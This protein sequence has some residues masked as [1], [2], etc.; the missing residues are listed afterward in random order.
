MAGAILE[1]AVIGEL[2]KAALHRGE[3]ARLHFSR[4]A[5]GVEVDVV[6]QQW[7]SGA[8]RL[9]PLEVRT[10]ATT[11]ARMARGIRGLR[12]DFG[13]MVAPGYVVCRGDRR[14]PLGD[15][16]TSLPLSEPQRR[17]WR[18]AV[19]PT[20]ARPAACRTPAPARHR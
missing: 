7:E 2:L 9:I 19:P 17:A 6:A 5:T 13:G 4:T 15:D 12:A 20:R 8:E 18:S 10:S 16:V 14:L 1:T 3:T 11:T